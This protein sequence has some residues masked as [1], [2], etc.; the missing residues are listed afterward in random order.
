MANTIKGL[1]I[2]D[3]SALGGGLGTGQKLIFTDMG[4]GGCGSKTD[5]LTLC[6]G[7]STTT[8]SFHFSFKINQ[9]QPQNSTM[10]AST[11]Y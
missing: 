9:K 1:F 8:R 5:K 6:E 2:Y 10:S 7:G 4:E 3:I 11:N